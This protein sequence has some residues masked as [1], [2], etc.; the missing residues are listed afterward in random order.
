MQPALWK[1]MKQQIDGFRS[2]IKKMAKN[3][4]KNAV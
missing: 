1:H 2:R 3:E 4:N